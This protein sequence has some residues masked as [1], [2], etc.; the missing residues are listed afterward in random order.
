MSS[1]GLNEEPDWVAAALCLSATILLWLGAALWDSL[2]LFIMGV[3]PL[4]IAIFIPSWFY[5]GP[6]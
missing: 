4:A 6:R 2:F 1:V 3:P 5:F